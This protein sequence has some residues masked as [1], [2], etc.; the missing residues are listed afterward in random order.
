MKSRTLLAAAIGMAFA[1]P[2]AYARITTV[3]IDNALSQNPAFGGHEIP[4]VGRYQKILGV[5]CGEL[6]PSDPKNAV[7]VD[8][9]FADRNSA[10]N[11]PY[12]FDFYILKP[13]NLTNGAHKVM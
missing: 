11:V 7:I 4:G 1:V 9:E 10:G 6:N 2:Q 3:T 5:A 13:I 8:I 12:C